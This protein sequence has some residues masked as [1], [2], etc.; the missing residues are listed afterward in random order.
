MPPQ[1]LSALHTVRDWWRMAVSALNQAAVFCGHGC[2]NTQDEAAWLL[3]HSL[4]LPAN[5]LET[6]L[7][8]RLTTP[9]STAFWNLLRRRIDSRQPT[10]Y[11]LQEAWLCGQRF[12][13]DERV[14]IPRSYLAFLIEAGFSP[15]I[16]S[17]EGV[18]SILDLCT[19]SGCLAILLAKA[20]PHASIDAV[21]VSHAA[22]AV[23]RR[24]VADYR[25]QDRIRLLESDLYARLPAQK[26]DLII[27]NPPYVTTAS[28]ADLP[29]EYQAEPA[30]SLHG[31]D[32]GMDL[33]RRIVSGAQ[34]RLKPQGLLAVEIGHNKALAQAACAQH[35]LIWPDDPGLNDAVFLI[36]A[37]DMKP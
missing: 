34:Q 15:W 19:G 37:D 20:F 4:H 35:A 30:L 33:V 21:D 18:G 8:A 23:A 11:L 17:P 3:T 22:L 7:D 31:G 32:D 5:S 6:F 28:M 26:Y 2:D 13:V 1:E 12:Y 10:A 25:L 14:I 36:Q 27:S 9:E 16:P 24:N 29:P